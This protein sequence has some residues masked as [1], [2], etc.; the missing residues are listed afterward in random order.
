MSRPRLERHRQHRA[1]ELAEQ[2]APA[3]T[4]K[5]RAGRKPA[6]KAEHNA[7]GVPLPAPIGLHNPAATNETPAPAEPSSAQAPAAADAAELAGAPIVDVVF[8]ADTPETES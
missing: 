1:P 3:K 8:P 2:T 7:T 6:N 5:P 4:K